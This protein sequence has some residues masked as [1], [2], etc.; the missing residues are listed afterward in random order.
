MHFY[1][2]EVVCASLRVFLIKFTVRRHVN[3]ENRAL[4][5]QWASAYYEI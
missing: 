3:M 1:H 5:E 4:L 2:T